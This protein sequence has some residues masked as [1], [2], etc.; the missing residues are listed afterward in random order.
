MNSVPGGEEQ[1]IDC[2]PA[3]AL[4]AIIRVYHLCYLQ[5]QSAHTMDSQDLESMCPSRT[6][7]YLAI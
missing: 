2:I 3:T 4:D 1:S 7:S 6:V 5:R